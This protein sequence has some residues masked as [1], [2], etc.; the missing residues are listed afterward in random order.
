MRRLMHL[1][2]R[3]SL[4]LRGTNIS[5]CFKAVIPLFLISTDHIPIN[6][7]LHGLEPFDHIRDIPF[8]ARLLIVHL[9]S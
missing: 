5:N 3:K 7:F 8:L 6:M 4:H 1:K 9:S 2:K